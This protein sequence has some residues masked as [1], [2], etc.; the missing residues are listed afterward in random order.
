MSTTPVPARS[1][2]QLARAT[3]TAVAIPVLAAFGLG[4]CSGTGTVDQADVESEAATQLAEAVGSDTEPDIACP[5]DL[6]AEVGETMVCELSVEGDTA[7]YEVTIEV[8]EVD[9]GD[10]SFDVQVADE[11]LEDS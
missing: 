9:G 6:T 1:A 4:A 10:T 8:T 2:R 5:G 3:A 11:P 7:V